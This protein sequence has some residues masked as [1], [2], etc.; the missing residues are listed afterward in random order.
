MSVKGK[1]GRHRGYSV[2]EKRNETITSAIPVDNELP[3]D[4]SDPPEFVIYET[5]YQWDPL[6]LAAGAITRVP[7][8][9]G[10][11]KFIP[12]TAR[13]AG[14]GPWCNQQNGEA[15]EVS[16]WVHLQAV[17]TEQPSITCHRS[18]AGTIITADYVPVSLRAEAVA[19]RPGIGVLFENGEVRKECP[20]Q[21]NTE[22]EDSGSASEE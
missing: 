3:K 11:R 5:S 20:E 2:V 15:A 13:E 17:L 19:R 16:V 14:S 7:G 1:G 18:E 21:S 12:V 22:G 8:D 6:L 10:Y 4:S 9:S